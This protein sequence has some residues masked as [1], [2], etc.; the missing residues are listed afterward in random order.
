VGI[1]ASIAIAVV[2]VVILLLL[3]LE[4]QYRR[5]PGNKLELTAGKWQLEGL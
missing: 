4:V 1:I 3:A 2:G 5:R